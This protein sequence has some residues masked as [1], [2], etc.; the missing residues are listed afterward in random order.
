MVRTLE[1]RRIIE[2]CRALEGIPEQILFVGA[3]VMGL[4]ATDLLTPEPR[5]TEDVDIVAMVIDF[6]QRI[7]L[8]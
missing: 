7:A 2:V 6:A 5:A 8:D 1:V 3:S 4:L